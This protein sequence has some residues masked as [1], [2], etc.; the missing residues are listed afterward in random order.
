[1]TELRDSALELAG[2][3]WHVLPVQPGGK[4]PLGRLAPQGVDSASSCARRV[5]AWWTAAPTANVGVACAASGLAVVDVD[6]RNGGDDRLH[7]LERTLGPLPDTVRS[8]TG[9]GGLHVLLKHPGGRLRGDLGAGVDLKAR[10][11]VVAPPSVH[12]SGRRYE[13]EIA[14]DELPIVEAPVA[15]ARA[16]TEASA[17]PSRCVA[18]AGDESDDPLLEIAPIEYFKVLAGAVPDRRGF[19]RCPLPDH[20]DRTPSCLVY[21]T[22]GQGWYCFGCRRGGTIYDLASLLIGGPHGTALKGAAFERIG[23]Q[24]LAFYERGAVAA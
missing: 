4:A 16:M 3:G 7:D 17:R 24:L 12:P 18:A 19:V 1:M 11:Y 15:W 2:R 13:W 23:Y 8:L 20:E 21:E 9:G 6:P 14:P 5:D 22:A 10:G